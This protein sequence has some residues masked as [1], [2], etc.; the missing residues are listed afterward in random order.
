MRA[1]SNNGTGHMCSS[2]SRNVSGLTPTAVCDDDITQKTVDGLPTA[3][4][5]GQEVPI[6][7]FVEA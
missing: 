7:S 3:A 2:S 5:K 4:E 6:C 1:N